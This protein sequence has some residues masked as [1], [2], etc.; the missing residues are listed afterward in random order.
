MSFGYGVDIMAISG[1]A[2]K[3]YT[4]YK[5][6]PSDYRNISDE[7]KSLHI[8]INN[9]AHHFQSNTLSDNK[10]WEGQEVLRG[11]INVLEDL[12]A[13]IV[14]YNGLASTSTSQVLQRIKLGTEDIATLRVRLISNTTLLNGFIQRLDIL[15]I[16]IQYT[17]IFPAVTRIKYKLGWIVFFVYVA[18]YQK[19]L[20]FPSLEASIPKMPTRNS[21]K[22]FL[23][24]VLQQT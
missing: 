2:L 15:T 12:D 10:R 7:V 17:N 6:A 22:A 1:L 3:V 16:N 9:A 4:A 14:K 18:Q 13:L 20:L 5:D 23:K 21:A 24:L 19:T 8:I 11:C